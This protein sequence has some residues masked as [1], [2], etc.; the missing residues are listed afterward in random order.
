MNGY[1]CQDFGYLDLWDMNIGECEAH[2]YGVCPVDEGGE[3]CEQPSRYGCS[4]RYTDSCDT[5]EILEKVGKYDTVDIIGHPRYEWI[6]K[7]ITI[8]DVIQWGKI[9]FYPECSPEYMCTWTDKGGCIKKVA[10][11][12]GHGYKDVKVEYID[13]DY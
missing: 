8:A 13:Y 2:F 10:I 4:Y 9:T 5:N 7:H 1:T 11:D 12:Y 3:R 6:K